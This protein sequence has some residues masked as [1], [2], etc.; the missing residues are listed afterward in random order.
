MPAVDNTRG[1][2]CMYMCKC[3][4]VCMCECLFVYVY[5][6]V[7]CECVFVYICVCICECV[8]LLTW[9]HHPLDLR[10][11]LLLQ[12]QVPAGVAVGGVVVVG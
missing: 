9:V 8:S 1:S 7:M 11:G 2:V 5:M 3:V 12:E 4:F 6:C 10:G